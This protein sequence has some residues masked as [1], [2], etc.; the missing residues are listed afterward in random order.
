[1]FNDT[2]Y[3]V[4]GLTLLL[5]V[6]SIRYLRQPLYRKFIKKLTVIS[7]ILGCMLFSFLLVMQGGS[8]MGIY[9]WYAS[10]GFWNFGFYEAIL[11]FVIKKRP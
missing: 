8:S 6:F 5:N 11:L 9:M 3:F 7:L 2:T 4:I 1:M 10:I